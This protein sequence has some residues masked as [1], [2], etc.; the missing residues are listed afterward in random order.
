MRLIPAIDILDS[1]VVRLHQG[2]YADSVEYS[3]SPLEQLADY[4]KHGAQLVH[5]VDLDAAKSGKFVNE[6][7]IRGLLDSADIDLQIAGGIRSEDDLK[8]R[9][10]LGIQ[11]VVVGSFVVSNT[12]DFCAWLDEYGADKIVAAVDVKK[13]KNG[14]FIPQ[15]KG[16]TESSHVTLFALLDQLTRSGLKHLL[17]TDISRDGMLTGPNYDLY[18]EI[19]ERY[20]DIVVQA[21]GGVSSIADLD[22]LEALGIKEAISG[23]ALLDGRI[24]MRTAMEKF[25]S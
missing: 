20:P 1:K 4:K 12:D 22:L 23:K 8:Q 17:C 6:Q 16:W 7:V 14:K 25:N 11:R 3:N 2:D 15:I 10:D 18:V 5:I 19:Q 9:I 21:S 13:N 24:D